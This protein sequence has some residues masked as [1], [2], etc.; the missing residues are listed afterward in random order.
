MSDD[1]H[2]CRYCKQN[3]PVDEF[4]RGWDRKKREKK[5]QHQCSECRHKKRSGVGS[6]KASRARDC[7]HCGEFRQ[8]FEYPY[9]NHDPAQTCVSC[10]EQAARNAELAAIPEHERLA[11]PYRA[12]Y[13]N[14]ISEHFA[15]VTIVGRRG[16]LW[17]VMFDLPLRVTKLTKEYIALV[18]PN[19]ILDG[20]GVAEYEVAL[21]AHNERVRD[22]DGR[23]R[24][25]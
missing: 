8:S 16:R 24:D 6:K 3:K 5:I 14:D 13:N 10:I 22:G 1:L 18:I 7:P 21:A 25:E 17:L 12:L 11:E 9:D 2:F 23:K 15:P 19:A 4:L 20:P